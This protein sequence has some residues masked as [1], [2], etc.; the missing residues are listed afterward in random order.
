M[1]SRDRIDDRQAP[2]RV[3]VVDDQKSIVSALKAQLQYKKQL[4][5]VLSAY[6]GETF[7]KAMKDLPNDQ[8]PQIVITD[9]NMPGMSGVE[10]VRRGKAL[11]PDVRFLILTVNDEEDIVFDAIQAGAEGYL[12]KDERF[13][14]IADQILGM[15]VDGEVPMTS[16]I[17]R[18]TLD[19]LAR[20]SGAQDHHDIDLDKF[21]LSDREKDVLELLVDGREYKQ[22]ASRLS[23]SPHT[24]RKHIA[25][26]YQKLHVSSKAQVINL[27]HGKSKKRQSGDV[28]YRTLLVDDHQIVLDGLSMML[29]TIP[30]VNVIKNFD[31]G[32][33]VIEYLIDHDIDLLISDVNMPHIN[34][35]ELAKQ[36]RAKYP[37]I[38]IMM[39]TVSDDKSQINEARS[40]GVHGYL[41]KNAKKNDLQAAIQTIMSG[42]SYY[43]DNL[44]LVS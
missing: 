20:S 14:I 42:G 29:G 21:D 24:V 26:I 25:N 7:L 15:A 43:F 35:I 22:I 9:I 10:L 19:L 34:G 39:L 12:M 4:E 28:G 36:V 37:D 30:K 38:K 18:K 6:D 33:K 40:V 17:A 13:A 44:S 16:R 27:I 23:I 2:V 41:L 32:Q 31:S 8:R 11:Y 5:V 3:G 1:E